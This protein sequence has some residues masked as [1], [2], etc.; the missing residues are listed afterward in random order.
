MLRALR[1]TVQA[2][3][4]AVPARRKP[5]LRRS[6]LPDALFATDLP[7]AADEA[8][9]AGFSAAMKGMGWRC[10][11]RNGWLVLDATVPVPDACI[12][13]R[14]VGE[15][16]CCISLL[17]RHPD[18]ATAEDYIRSVVKA[19]DAGCIPFERLCGQLHAAFAERL[20][21]HQPLPGG[22][23]PYLCFAYQQL[24]NE[25]G[26]IHDLYLHWPCQIPD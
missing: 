17:L 5:A 15:C 25:G 3:L 6:D 1:E 10:D 16:G 11:E 20:R 26:R 4:Y 22:L 18:R 2:A 7:L 12:P 23:L 14:L 19:A 8:A 13:E 24:Y 21:M 9:V